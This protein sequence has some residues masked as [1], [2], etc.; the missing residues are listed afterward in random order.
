MPVVGGLRLSYE[1][2]SLVRSIVATE[3]QDAAIGTIEGFLSDP[4]RE[5]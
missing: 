3:D 2:N 1:T 5:D 4:R